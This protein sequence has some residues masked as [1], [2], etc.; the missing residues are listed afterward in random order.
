MKING[1][2]IGVVVVILILW[3]IMLPKNEHNEHFEGIKP[4]VH[5]KLDKNG[6]AVYYSPQSPHMNGE[7]G[8]GVVPCPD[9]FDDNVTC[10]C[11]C[12]YY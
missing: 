9:K 4:R 3:C 11:C 12:N 6:N 2:F 10:W 5:A 1:W 7:Q 8:C